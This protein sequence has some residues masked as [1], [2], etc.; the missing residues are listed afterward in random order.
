MAATALTTTVVFDAWVKILH[1]DKQ[2]ELGCNTSKF[3]L[4]SHPNKQYMTIYEKEKVSHAL[5]GN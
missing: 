5:H 3:L 4:F 2:S 1:V